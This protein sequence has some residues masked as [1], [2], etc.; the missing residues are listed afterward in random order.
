MEQTCTQN[1]IRMKNE[2]ITVGGLGVEKHDRTTGTFEV[3]YYEKKVFNNVM[4]AFAFYNKLA[5][6]ASLYDTTGIPVCLEL[7]V[8]SE[9]ET[10]PDTKK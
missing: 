8:F 2:L 1:P 6:P 3:R 10:P 9:F 7:K 4:E 5:Y